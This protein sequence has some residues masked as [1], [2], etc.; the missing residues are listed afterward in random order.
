[1]KM[2]DTVG[3][4]DRRFR[5]KDTIAELKKYFKDIFPGGINLVL[6]VSSKGRFTDEEQACLETI[7]N[8][9][10]KDVS[11]ISALVVTHCDHMTDARRHKYVEEFRSDRHTRDIAAFMRKGTF[12]VGFPDVNELDS[13]ELKG[14]LERK[15]ESD[16]SKLRDLVCASDKMKL[17]KQLF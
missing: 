14:F 17:G 11:E 12:T 6:F 1:M 8:I 7:V 15:I 9:F 5:N 3:L 10:H 2:V 13:D 16:A 4:F